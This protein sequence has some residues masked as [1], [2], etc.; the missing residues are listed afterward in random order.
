MDWFEQLTGFREE[1][2]D[3]TKAKLLIRGECLHSKVNEQQYAVGR[4][5]LPTLA[6]L[7]N[8]LA[9]QA[10]RGKL[11]FRRVNGDVREL[12]RASGNKGALFQVASQFNLLEMMSP[13][14]TPED[15]VTGYDWDPT[16]GPACAIAA[17]AATIYRNYFVPVGNQTGQ[18]SVCQLDALAGV[19]ALLGEEL[20]VQP[21]ALW[22]MKNGYPQATESSVQ[23]IAEW[24]HNAPDQKLD[25]LRASL[26]IGLHWDV[27]VTDHPEALGSLV[28]QAFC[29]AIPVS[30]SKVSAR[31]WNPF[32]RLVLEAAYEATFL[33]AARN[34]ARG[35]SN[36]LYL[37]R[38]GGGAFG[39][40]DDWIDSAI[41]R[42]LKLFADCSLE[43]LLVQY[44]PPV[45]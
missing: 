19:R 36:R 44:R 31:L 10:P 34:A 4:L 16:Q 17:G 14:V 40:P 27:E 12:H 23:A 22:V 28:S 7:R 42:A 39:N 37:T 29:S 3:D 24:L 1:C 5:E 6:E 32:A 13:D 26:R 35:G 8:R 33:A 9:G 2:Y 41:H 30:Y 15:G 21:T 38:L 18:S 11:K 20:G 25:Q 43:V 45:R